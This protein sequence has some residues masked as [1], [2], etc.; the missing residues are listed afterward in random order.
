MDPTRYQFKGRSVAEQTLK[1]QLQK[2]L[3][4]L[5]D[6]DQ[7]SRETKTLGECLEF[8]L[9]QGIFMELVAFGKSDKP[10]GLFEI[11]LKFINYLILDV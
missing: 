9:K 4:A 3:D 10:E 11:V 2:V 6:E 7:I 1:P 5:L 8:S